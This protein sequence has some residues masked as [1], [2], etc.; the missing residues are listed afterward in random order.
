MSPIVLQMEYARPGF[1]SDPYGLPLEDR[2]RLGSAGVSYILDDHSTDFL[3]QIRLP[4]TLCYPPRESDCAAFTRSEIDHMRDVQIL[5]LTLFRIAAALGAVWIILFLLRKR[6]VSLVSLRS[7]LLSGSLLTI[8]L[9]LAII[10]LAIVA[11]DTFFTGFHTLF[12]EGDSWRFFYSDTLIR[13]YPQQ[14]WIDAALAVGLLSLAGA[15]VIALLVWTR[16][17]NVDG[18]LTE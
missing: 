15:I 14:F 3:A 18:T 2:I 10:L 16:L 1:P 7:S 12:F 13:L 17:R 6:I 5:A 4:G 11:W 8:G 9:I